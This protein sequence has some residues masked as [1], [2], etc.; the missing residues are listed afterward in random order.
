MYI[1]IS[2]EQIYKYDPMRKPVWKLDDLK[3]GDWTSK[4]TQ[5]KFIEFP[6][7]EVQFTNEIKSFLRVCNL[8]QN[9]QN[10]GSIYLHVLVT[11]HGHS[12]NPNDRESHS[13]QYTF[14]KS[15]RLNKYKKKIYKKTKN[16]LTGNT[17]QNEEYQKVSI[18]HP[19]P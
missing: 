14:W 9:M 2:E 3:Y 16:L 7:S 12:I 6:I 1:F 18:N 5:I 19:P 13:P 10:N 15:K 11:K 17:E 4:G 8:F